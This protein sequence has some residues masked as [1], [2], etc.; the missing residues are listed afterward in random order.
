MKGNKVDIVR[1][2]YLF[3]VSLIGIIF[4]L[5]GLISLISQLTTLYFPPP[6]MIGNNI[7]DLYTYQRIYSDLV[8]L[9]V[10]LLLFVLHWYFVVKERRLGK[11]ENIQYESNLNFFESI[12]FYELSFVGIVIFILSCRGIVEGFFNVVYPPPKMDALGKIIEE[13]IPYIKKDIG[14]I[15]NST[16][17]LII[18]LITFLIGFLRTQFSIHKVEN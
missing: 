4:F 3:G 1:N 14:R 18:G 7:E 2:I 12:F 11:I 10:G 16:I 17:S 13:S 6:G 8:F 15:I 5:S 9:L